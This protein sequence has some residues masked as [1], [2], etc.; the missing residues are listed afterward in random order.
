MAL[1]IE[2]HIEIYENSFLNDP[3]WGIQA[4]MP[5]PSLN[6]G[7]EFDHRGLAGA[8]WDSTPERGQR[9]AISKVKHIFWEIENRHIGHKLMVALELESAAE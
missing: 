1:P 9:F 6:V 4:S 2:Y 5:F 8:A 7:D 3:V